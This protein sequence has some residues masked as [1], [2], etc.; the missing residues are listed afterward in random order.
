M[1]ILGQKVKLRTKLD[2][3]RKD[4]DIFDDIWSFLAGI[5]RDAK[6]NTAIGLKDSK[7]VYW[8]LDQLDKPP[9]SPLSRWVLPGPVEPLV[10]PAERVEQV[11]YNVGA[12]QPTLS[13]VSLAFSGH[14]EGIS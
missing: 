8:C 11:L 4:V 3:R 1:L 12:L 9:G 13:S 6:T 5:L 14:F 2:G 7:M 10:M